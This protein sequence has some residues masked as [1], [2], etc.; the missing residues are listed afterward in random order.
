VLHQNGTAYV[1]QELASDWARQD[2]K[3]FLESAGRYFARVVKV[4]GPGQ[5]GRPWDWPLDS[6]A[7][8]SGPT[9]LCRMAASRLPPGSSGGQ[10]S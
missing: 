1:V 10:Q 6:G 2:E 3:I 7:R 9:D 4:P 5:L 8:Y